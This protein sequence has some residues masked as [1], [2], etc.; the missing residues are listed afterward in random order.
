L[1]KTTLEIPD[2]LYRQAEVRA[3]HGHREIKDLVNDG[4]RLV[5]G[6]DKRDTL[7]EKALAVLDEVRRNPPYPPGRVQAM[8]DEANRLRKE[9]WE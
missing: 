4:L 8:I 6:S 3:A 5:L 7:R 2:D 1:V 9:S